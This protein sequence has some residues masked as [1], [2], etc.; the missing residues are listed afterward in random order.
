MLPYILGTVLGSRNIAGNNTD[1]VL[2]WHNRLAGKT[3]DLIFLECIC[4]R[5]VEKWAMH[6]I[7]HRRSG[8]ELGTGFV[9]PYFLHINIKLSQENKE[10]STQAIYTLC[11]LN[12]EREQKR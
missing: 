1:N 9:S 10:A 5:R 3:M 8:R 6:T 4:F 7:I 2:P 11:F 12:L